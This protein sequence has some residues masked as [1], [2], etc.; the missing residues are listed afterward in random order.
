MR[1]CRLCGEPEKR[2]GMFT[3][4]ARYMGIC[5]DC[6]NKWIIHPEKD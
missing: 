5:A 4:V 6:I 3:T 1:T 2:D